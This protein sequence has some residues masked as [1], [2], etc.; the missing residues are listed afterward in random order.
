MYLIDIAL[1]MS[2]SKYQFSVPRKSYIFAMI[3]RIPLSDKGMDDLRA[4]SSNL[5]VNC[6][7]IH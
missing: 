3:A 6:T 1:L 2:C 5:G 4:K 7:D